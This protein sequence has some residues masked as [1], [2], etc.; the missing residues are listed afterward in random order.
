MKFYN[1][2]FL[3]T[4]SILTVSCS[5]DKETSSKETIFECNHLDYYYYNDEATTIGSL[6][7]NYLLVAFDSIQSNESIHSFINSKT[8]FDPDYVS[9]IY[10]NELYPY[11]QVPIKL[12]GNKTCEE[13]TEIIFD[14]RLNPSTPYAHYTMQTDECRDPTGEIMGDLCV[15]SY[16]SLFYV[17]VNDVNDLSHLTSTI[18][19]TQTFLVSQ[20]AFDPEIFE[21]RADETSMGDALAMANYFH[22]TGHFVYTSAHIFKV[23]VE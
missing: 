22:E 11:K 3:L 17:R 21:L 19:E 8:F 23:P 20:N 14:V 13:I 2:L 5:K 18:Q 7:N 6:S 10:Q 16:S 9:I 4:I 1:A 12:N 15:W